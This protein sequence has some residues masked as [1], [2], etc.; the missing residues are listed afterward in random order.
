MQIH[1]LHFLISI[2]IQK[3]IKTNAVVPKQPETT[4]SENTFA[5]NSKV[6]EK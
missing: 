6:K 2:Q 3:G 5:F 4:V 1:L